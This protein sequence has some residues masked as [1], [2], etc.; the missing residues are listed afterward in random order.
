M[1]PDATDPDQ[2]SWI[3]VL[4][5]YGLPVLGLIFFG[6]IGAHV[7]RKHYA[8]IRAREAALARLPAMASRTLEADKIVA[9]A[10][11]VTAE[12]VIT[13]DYFK[14]F[15]AGLRNI[16]GGRVRSYETLLD[17]ARRE[18]VLRLKEQA[19]G[20]H[21]IA[22]LRLETSAIMKDSAKNKNVAVCVIAYGTAVRCGLDFAGRTGA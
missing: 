6:F 20:A 21:V 2:I 7:E 16:F 1:S 19:A 10:R 11:L 13:Q 4:L 8:S 18:A 3:I 17:R 12:V 22:N 14:R 15:L 5:V 9:E